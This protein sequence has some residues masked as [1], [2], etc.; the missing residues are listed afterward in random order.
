M[1]R[2]GRRVENHRLPKAEAARLALA[3]EIGADGHH[4][5]SG[6]DAATDRP[7]LARLPK[8]AIL[9]Q[10]WAAQCVEEG[11]RLRWRVTDALPPCAEQVCSPYAPDARYSTKRE[12]TGSATRRS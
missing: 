6:I 1:P 3:A 5:L 11:G 8:V 7:E 10:V 2:Y 4:L 12:Q 9:R